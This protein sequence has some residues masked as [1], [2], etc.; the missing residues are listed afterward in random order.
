MDLADND[1]I[2]LGKELDKAPSLT[3]VWEVAQQIYSDFDVEDI[4]DILW[5]MTE[6]VVST[7]EDDT[8]LKARQMSFWLFRN[9]LVMNKAMHYL[10]TQK[11][12]AKK[13]SEGLAKPNS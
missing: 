7:P 5:I 9:L 12:P 8:S 3:L 2:Y 6:T 4:E 11:M 13:S 10:S 1:I